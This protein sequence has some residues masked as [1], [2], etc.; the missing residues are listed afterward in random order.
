L[1]FVTSIHHSTIMAKQY[2]KN[3]IYNQTSLFGPLYA[4]LVVISPPKEIRNAIA[5]IKK[6]WDETA[7]I[8]E[9]NLQSI[10]HITLTDRLTD[11]AN[12]S[13]T[14][15]E[16]LKGHQKFSVR[17]HGIDV[18]DHQPKKTVFLKIENPDPI[19][20]L[21]QSLKSATKSPHLSLAKT[22]QPETFEKLKNQINDFE[23][24]TEWVCEEIIVLKK[25]M[26]EKHLGFKDKIII[27]LQ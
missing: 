6:D 7:N 24:D 17:L 4:Y 25:L 16:L 8:G 1:K 19:I 22:L 2:R 21:M 9:R 26:S 20:S 12:F 15:R 14:V 27:P 3:R 18:F 10:G 23:F 5:V 13:E 11:D